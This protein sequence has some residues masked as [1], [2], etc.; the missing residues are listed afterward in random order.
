M[1]KTIRS[2]ITDLSGFMEIKELYTELSRL[3]MSVY[4]PFDYLLPS[5]RSF[6]SDLYDTNITENSTLKQSTR[7][8]S[9]QKLMKINLLKRLESSVDSFRITLSKFIANVDGIIKNI[10]A[11][12]IDGIQKQA[13]FIQVD[14]VNLDE[15]NDDWLSDDFSIGDKVKINLADMN[16]LGWKQDLEKD[17]IVA[18]A[19]LEEMERVTPVH[20]SKLKDLKDLIANKL[21]NPI[22]PGNQ[23]VLIFT[24]FADTANYL[25]KNISHY[26]SALGLASAKIT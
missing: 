22:N 16:T 19:I 1:P 12:E 2:G 20:D 15:E 5:K 24:A 11:F 9:L 26:A 21:Q 18:H 8:R 6:Y 10:D 4:S 3:N 14:D 25:Y 23:K 7:E 13:E 17:L